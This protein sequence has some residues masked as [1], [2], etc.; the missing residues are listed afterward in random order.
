MKILKSIFFL[1]FVLVHISSAQKKNSVYVELGGNAVFYSF[2]YDRI[3]QLSE[4]LKIA[5]RVGFMYLPLSDIK[6]NKTFGDFNIPLELNL[7]FAKNSESKNFGE[8]GVGLNL[9][10]MK[11]GYTIGP[12]DEV[13]RNNSRLARVTTLRAGFRHQKPQGGLMYRIGLLVPI[14]QDEFS[15]KR[16]GDDIFYRLYGGLSLGWTF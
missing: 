12:A 15:E 16:V 1:L 11:N 3:I 5:P 7:L 14:L 8:F 4:K 2:N 10:S 6:S 13:V 9:I